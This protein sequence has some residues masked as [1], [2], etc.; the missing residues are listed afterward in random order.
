MM[1]NGPE[2]S[3]DVSEKCVEQYRTNKKNEDFGY[4]NA[5]KKETREEKKPFD[6]RAIHHISRFGYLILLGK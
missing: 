4:A 2:N 6:F 1:P 3:V 5:K